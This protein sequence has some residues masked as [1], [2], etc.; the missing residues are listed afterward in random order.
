MGGRNYQHASEEQ[1]ITWELDGG[2]YHRND[3]ATLFNGRLYSDSRALLVAKIK[4]HSRGIP[5]T[6]AAFPAVVPFLEFLNYRGS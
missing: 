1:H 2:G 3:C 6:L 4:F 5:R